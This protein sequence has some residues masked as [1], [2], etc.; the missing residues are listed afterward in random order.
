VHC[1]APGPVTWLGALI[2]CAALGPAGAAGWDCRSAAD[3]R[4]WECRQVGEIVAPAPADAAQPTTPTAPAPQTDET[5]TPE[6]AAGRTN[7]ER[8]AADVE[9][10][11]PTTSEAASTGHPSAPPPVDVEPKQAL[12]TEPGAAP[13]IAVTANPAVSADKVADP[14]PPPP[15]ATPSSTEGRVPTAATATA[16][17]RESSSVGPAATQDPPTRTVEPESRIEA[18]RAT[19]TASRGAQ[20]GP[21]KTAVAN[22]ES[23]DPAQSS[24]DLAGATSDSVFTASLDAG[25]D[26]QNCRIGTN[27]GPQFTTADPAGEIVTV[28]AD[29]AVATL[30]PQVAEFNGNVQLE[31]GDIILRADRLTL[32]RDADEA[33]ASGEV[34]ITRPDLRVAGSSADY[35]MGA[36]TGTINDASY[37]LPAIRGRGDAEKAALLADGITRY[38]NISYTTCSPNDDEWI[39]S[40]DRLE[41]DHE[42]GLATADH[43]TLRF[44]GAPILYAPTFTFPIDD[45]RRSGVLIPTVGSTG[46]TGLDISVPY[47]FNLAPNYDLTLVPRLMSKRGLQ[48]GG[49]F[50]FLTDNTRG[51]LR[52]EILPDDREVTDGDSTR[53]SA[54]LNTSTWFNDRAQAAL[55]LNYVSDDDYLTDLGDSI[56]VASTVNLERT[57]E[58]TYRGDTWTLLARA[59][60][61]QTLDESLSPYSRLPQFKIDLED[62]GGL[63]GLT[64]HL[65]AEY[66]NFDRDDSV[67]GHRIDVL[68]ALSLPWRDIWRSFEPKIGARYTGYDLR[69][70][71]AGAD[72]S[73]SSFSGLFS[74]DGRLFFERQ[75][76]YWGA[77]TTQTLEPRAYYLYVP[78]DDQADQPIFD[79]SLLDFNFDNLFREN[80]FVGGDRFGDANQLTLAL[81]SRMLGNETGR[82]L[83][84][85]SVGQILYFDDREVGLPG[86]AIEDDSSSAVVAEIDATLSRDW[87]SRAGLEWDPH[88]G[89]NGT[90]DQALAQLAYRDDAKGRLFNATYRL[91]EG[92]IHQTDFAAVWPVSES[93][94]L[95]GRHYYSLRDDRL[96]EVLGG[97]EYSRCCWKVRTLLRQFANTADDEDFGF[98][99]QLELNG[100]GSFGDD[101]DSVLESRIYGYGRD[102]IY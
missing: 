32:N 54:S 8:D 101:I 29:A 38:E 72:A 5:P 62:P 40:A 15:S 10:Q 36:K 56:S 28:T 93:V 79:T 68:P 27:N 51:E 60:N 82:E 92:E 30:D 39:L 47:Y 90:I 98:F 87:R 77:D 74:A 26:W 12:K 91:R 25:I 2:A 14:E 42:E 85:A 22:N 97:L 81:T 1:N 102:A 75:T 66:V 45:R 21:A 78:S 33:T 94:K 23:E 84:R 11:V 31:Q 70:Q 59:Q 63:G 41:I 49:E 35:Q 69:D 86:A 20:V 80:R 96:L 67:S 43:A 58:F 52:G 61:Y 57:G 95:I 9:P 71:A 99:V 100:L 89:D 3:G 53:G 65:D 88:D 50:R 64:Y 76:S 4:G 17:P 24:E 18:P 83:L 44:L 46:N 55:R 37:R 6:P 16:T 34:L 7:Y 73:P 13:V 48:L 19:A